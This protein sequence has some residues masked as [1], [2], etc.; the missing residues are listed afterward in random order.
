MGTRA[1]GG[2]GR[3][4]VA[5]SRFTS[6]APPGSAAA[7]TPQEREARL[8]AGFDQALRPL[9]I[10]DDTTRQVLQPVLDDSIA[11]FLKAIAEEAAVQQEPDD[12]AL[13]APRTVG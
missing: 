2:P 7:D 13:A 9:G 1:G 4:R 5:G 6:W 3:A 8:R 11:Q 12:G 10:D